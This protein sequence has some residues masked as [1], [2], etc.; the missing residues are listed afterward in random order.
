MI[1]IK[2]FFKGFK[3]GVN[4]FGCKISIIV[5]SVLLSV[6]YLIGV[7]VTS[8][9]AKV[10]GKHFLDMKISKSRETYWSELNLR[11]KTREEYYRQF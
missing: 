9:I 4:S 2:L 7:G 5:N 11:K 6:V 3:K 1:N 10:S 8:L